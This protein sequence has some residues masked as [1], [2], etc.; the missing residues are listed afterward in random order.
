[1]FHI[2]SFTRI[3]KILKMSASPMTHTVFNSTLPFGWQA[4]PRSRL[5]RSILLN[6]LYLKTRWGTSRQHTIHPALAMGASSKAGGTVEHDTGCP[7]Q[8]CRG[9]IKGALQLAEHTVVRGVLKGEEM[10]L[11]MDMMGAIL[12]IRNVYGLPRLTVVVK[13]D[14]KQHRYVDQ[15]QQPREPD[16]LIADC[17]LHLE[18]K[19]TTII[20]RN[21]SLAP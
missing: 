21:S 17:P 15:Q 1:M 19:V 2:F 14:G 20:F 13:R 11:V 6:L 10:P 18:G 16:S 3:E 7:Q 5:R 4:S 9:K 12:T 8:K